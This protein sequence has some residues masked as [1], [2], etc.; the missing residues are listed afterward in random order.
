MIDVIQLTPAFLSGTVRA[1]PSKS[2]AHR[3]MIVA[4][5]ADSPTTF[6]LGTDAP[7]EDILATMDCLRALG[8]TLTESSP[9][10]WQ[11]VPILPQSPVHPTLNCRESGSTLRFMLPLGGLFASRTCGVSFSGAG[12]L[13]ERPIDPLLDVLREHGVTFS[14]NR[15]PFTLGGDLC[16]GTFRLPG[17]ASSQ[18][19]SGLL[20]ALPFLKGDSRIVLTS[21]LESAAYVDMTIHTLAGFGMCVEKTE[22]GFFCPGEQTAVSPG[23]IKTEGDWSSAAF[24]LAAGAIGS[25]VSC[26]GL[27]LESLQPD[28]SVI[29]FL[30]L[31][32]AECVVSEDLVTVSPGSLYGITMDAS[33]APDLVPV[34]AMV[35]SVAEGETVITNAARL[36]MKESDRLQAIA[37]CIQA[38]GGKCE[39]FADGLRIQG[40]RLTGGMVDGANDHRIVMAAAI[41]S[42]RCTE[43]MTIRGSHAISK[44]YPAFFDDFTAL[45]GRPHV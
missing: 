17:D 18:F 11:I 2:D 36:R 39:L 28:R 44:S 45:G 20:F 26:N 1:I 10:R 7:G 34:L 15:L 8:A 37:G 33:A 6:C 4:A 25:P 12:R 40:G 30:R 24:F 14:N 35:A 5:L 31:F 29:D 42:I 21:A 23:T 43:P 9:G 16:S 32:G 41:A 27:S 13:P 3:Q 19:V 38:L 22:D